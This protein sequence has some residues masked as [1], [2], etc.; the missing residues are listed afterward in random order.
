MLGKDDGGQKN[1]AFAFC[2]RKIYENSRFSKFI[3]ILQVVSLNFPYI[4]IA[5]LWGEASLGDFR[6]ASDKHPVHSAD[7]RTGTQSWRLKWCQSW[8]SCW[9]L[10]WSA[11]ATLRHILALKGWNKNHGGFHGIH[12]MGSQK[13]GFRWFTM[14]FSLQ[15]E[16]DKLMEKEIW[17]SVISHW[18]SIAM[19]EKTGCPSKWMVKHPAVSVTGFWPKTIEWDVTGCNGM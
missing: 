1:G 10:R 19:F 6:F 17:D 11:T 7:S 2:C 15:I 3:K 18:F 16:S 5:W 4:S 9:M 12:F 13:N 14:I 8:R